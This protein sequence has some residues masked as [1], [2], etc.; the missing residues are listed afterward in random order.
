MTP[1]SQRLQQHKRLVH[2]NQVVFTAFSEC[3]PMQDV[4]AITLKGEYAKKVEEEAIHRVI[5]QHKKLTRA[6]V[7]AEMDVLFADGSIVVREAVYN[8]ED[9]ISVVVN[10]DALDDAAA[11]RV[12]ELIQSALRQLDGEHGKIKFGKPVSFAKSEIAWLNLH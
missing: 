11:V 7:T 1:I 10:A 4:N 8:T 9:G 5:A 12:M 6:N 3:E 2:H